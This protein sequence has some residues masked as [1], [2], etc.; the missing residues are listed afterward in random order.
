[1]PDTLHRLLTTTVR[2]TVTFPGDPGWDDARQAYNLAVDQRPRAVVHAADAADVQA[3]MRAAR[4]AGL[5]VAPQGTGHGCGAMASLDE[6]I[7]LRVDRL[8]G[9][10]IDAA[11]RRVRAGTG[12]RWGE[13]TASL[14]AHGL[15][16]LAGTSPTARVAGY[17]L[18]GGIG[19]LARAH[20]LACN[21]VEAVEIVT[22]DGELRRADASS[23]ADLFWA[24]RGGGGN[25]GVVTA[26]EF[27]VVPAP[28][29]FAGALFWDVTRAPEVLTAWT[30]W[31]PDAPD[32]LTSTARV[33]QFPPIPDIPEPFR[34]RSFAMVQGAFLG[35]QE[36]GADLWAPLR[37]LG[38]EIDTLAVIPPSAL[39]TINMDPP[40]PLPYAGDGG[41]LTA[42][43]PEAAAALLAVHGGPGTSSPLLSVEIRHL[44]G[45]MATAPEGAGALSAIPAPFAWFGVGAIPDPALVDAV[46]E[47]IEHVA[48]ALAPWD[49]GCAYMN[50]AET[51][52]GGDILFG[53]DVHARLRAVRAAYDPDGLLLANHEVAPG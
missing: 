49:A 9:L 28:E 33:L 3:V 22:A 31:I 8:G 10:E 14:D 41:L 44:G 30:E 25:F 52:C 23:D 13:V 32:T 50:F 2:G 24:V 34:G 15:A 35:A 12:V 17:T 1:M 11:A 20:G 51:P 37:A 40:E 46:R 48:E 38:P 29:V 43:T 36:Q 39:G 53:A 4:A 16:A 7:L 45:A 21:A 47:G 18:G 6:A 42:F 5:R 19:F 27:R 26:I